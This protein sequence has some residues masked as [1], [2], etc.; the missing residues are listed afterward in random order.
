MQIMITFKTPDAVEYALEDEFS[1]YER[2]CGDGECMDDDPN[3]P[4]CEEVSLKVDEQMEDART[5]IEQFV[6]H[7]EMVNILFDTN[8]NTATVIKRR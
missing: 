1:S 8:E 3:C 7:G 6:Q 5:F 4:D 2:T